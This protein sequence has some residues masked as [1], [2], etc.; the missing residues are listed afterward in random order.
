[1]TVPEEEV[2]DRPIRRKLR[3]LLIWICLGVLA[4]GAAGYAFVRWMA[5]LPP[6]TL[7]AP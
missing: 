4:L 1:L 3:R 7:K 5:S 6:G 2:D